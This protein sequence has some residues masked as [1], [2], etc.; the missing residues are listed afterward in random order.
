[1]NRIQ[2]LFHRKQEGILSIYFTAGYPRLQDTATIIVELARAGTDMIEIGIPFSDPLADGPV[3]QESS[4]VAL[5]NGMSLSLLFEQLRTIRNRTQVPLVLMGYLN[6]ILQYGVL[7]FCKDAAA[8][9]IDALIIPDLPLPVFQE[10]WKAILA[11]YQLNMVFLVTPQTPLDRVKEID[12]MT[13][14]FI[15]LVT[16]AAITGGQLSFSP[17]QKNYFEQ[18]QQAGLRNPLLAGFGIRNKGDAANISKYVQG[19]I[20]GSSFITALQHE[21]GNLPQGIVDF[22]QSFQ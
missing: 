2:D 8:C 18:V 1:M 19:V 5:D 12:E 9:G 20:V 10:E 13:E 6:P 16:A 4:K 15:Y 22:V 21:D 11:E 14:G 17:E 7:R 3:I